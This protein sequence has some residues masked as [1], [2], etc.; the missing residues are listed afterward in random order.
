MELENALQRF[1]DYLEAERGLSERTMIAYQTDLKQFFDFLQHNGGLSLEDVRLPDIRSFLRHEIKRGLT[2]PSMMRKFS[3]LRTFFGYLTR[4]GFLTTDPSEY[5]SQPRKRRTVPSV[6]SEN[7]IREMM[8]LPDE[9]TL[10]GLRDRTVLEFIYGTGVRLSEL[11]GLD[12]GHFLPFSDTIK[13]RGKGDKDRLVPW[14]GQAREVFLRYQSVRFS[15]RPVTAQAL[16]P[17]RTEPAFSTDGKRR[18]SARTVQ[19]IV[20]RYL[21][22]ISSSSGLSPHSLRHAFATHLLNNGADLRAVQELLGHESLSTTQIYTHVSMS[23]LKAVYKK[24]H[25][26]A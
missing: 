2:H 15:L 5:L 9:S 1:F 25:P 10:K 24:A 21:G 3:T 17:F 19:R 20:Y 8:A 13:V 23:V 14:G 7:H 22:R 18:I 16:M 4:R 6:A 12:V 11:V 26:R